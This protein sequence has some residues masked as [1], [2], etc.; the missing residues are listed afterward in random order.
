MSNSTGGTST[1]MSSRSSSGPLTRERYRATAVAEQVHARVGWPKYPQGQGFIAA[2][3][4]TEQG[5]V[6]EPLTR[7]MVTTPS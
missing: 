2:T 6:M 1:W 3:S 4:M 5:Y 7:E